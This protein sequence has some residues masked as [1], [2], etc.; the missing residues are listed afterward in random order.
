MLIYKCT[1]SGGDNT[2]VC[3]SL[4]IE[5]F[6]AKAAGFKYCPYEK[7]WKTTKAY[8]AAKLRQF[9][10]H[11][12][13]EEL[14]TITLRQKS[15]EAIDAAFLQM[16]KA[17]EEYEISH[18]DYVA[19]KQE[20]QAAVELEILKANFLKSVPVG[21]Y[22]INIDGK[23]TILQ[24][25]IS[26][27]GYQYLKRGPQGEYIGSNLVYLQLLSGSD[28]QAAQALYAKTT[29][30]C[31]KCNR[32]LNDEVSIILG[33]GPDCGVAEHEAYKTKPTI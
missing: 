9:A 31:Y 10:D 4:K 29:G 14:S 24:V 20:L 12:C 1:E 21:N 32:T 22:I 13:Q 17:K 28:L 23:E 30:R 11:T 18:A 3:Q 19:A 5:R 7:L 8:N 27:K 2:Y 33:I 26:Q 25:R 6:L 15:I 16:N